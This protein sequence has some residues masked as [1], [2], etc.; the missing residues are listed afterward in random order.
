MDDLDLN[1]H[2]SEPEEWD[3][4][5]AFIKSVQETWF[6]CI[7]ALIS[8][9]LVGS[10]FWAVYI[11]LYKTV[12]SKCNNSEIQNSTNRRRSLS[13]AEVPQEI[14]STQ[15]K[16][17]EHVKNLAV[18]FDQEDV[19]NLSVV[20]DQDQEDVNNLSVV[21]DQDQ[22]DVN[23]LSVVVDQDQENQ[24]NAKNSSSNQ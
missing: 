24:T 7:P 22:E 11:C 5:E 15:E 23:N 1:F 17:Q 4:Q 6:L 20:L 2:I 8:G 10:L 9:F 14:N 16:D 18:V 3:A 12:L 19:N 13:M 21:L